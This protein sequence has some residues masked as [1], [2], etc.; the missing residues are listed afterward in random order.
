MAS[1]TQTSFPPQS[2]ACSYTDAAPD[3]LL[4]ASDVLAMVDFGQPCKPSQQAGHYHSGLTLL[5][6]TQQLESWYSGLPI[7]RGIDGD[8]NWSSNRDLLCLALYIDEQR[9]P[10]QREA[11]HQA[12]DRL[13]SA[14]QQ[15]GYPHLIRVWNYMADINQGDGEAER[16]KQFCLG[17]LQAFRE[18]GYDL[19]QFPSACALG[20]DGGDTVIYLLASRQAGVHFENPEQTSAYRYPHQYGPA[21]PSFARA[22]LAPWP[23]GRQ[24][25][26]SGTA[27]IV[28]HESL[29]SNTMALQLQA[30]CRN[31]DTLLEHVGTQLACPRPLRMDS[32]KVYLRRGSDV[33]AA[34]AA[35]EHHFGANTPALYLRADI[36]RS[37]LLVEIDGICNID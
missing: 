4:S 14:A 26:L 6:N 17:R 30:T 10:S 36:C 1:Q 20:H 11:V 22:T 7:S 5:D 31:V 9:F 3:T 12:Y 32:L 13:L 8:C 23:S 16:Y 37:E 34:R 29:H 35:V 27:S 24:L 2:I 25:Y 19:P 18:H 21:S 15:R 33:D 28:G